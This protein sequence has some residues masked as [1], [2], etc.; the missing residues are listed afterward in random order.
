MASL[1]LSA[2]EK[3][4][5][6]ACNILTFEAQKLERGAWSRKGPYPAPLRSGGVENMVYLGLATTLRVSEFQGSLIHLCQIF[7]SGRGEAEVG[8]KLSQEPV[9]GQLKMRE[10]HHDCRISWSLS[11]EHSQPSGPET[12]L[13]FPLPPTKS[14]LTIPSLEISCPSFSL[15]QCLLP[16]FCQCD[17]FVELANFYLHF[18]ALMRF[19]SIWQILSSV[20]GNS[21]PLYPQ[22]FCLHLLLYFLLLGPLLNLYWGI[23]ICPP[24]LF[25]SFTCF[26]SL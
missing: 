11:T 6:F 22:I 7:Y 25:T 23:L 20:L 9:E 1:G 21:Q 3:I 17:C 5:L 4:Y 14:F 18:S 13:A 8:R 12:D 16:P 15:K 2:E 24:D 10:H 19:F 26:S